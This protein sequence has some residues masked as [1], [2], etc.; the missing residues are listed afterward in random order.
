M[1]RS[2]GIPGVCVC[3]CGGGV[4]WG[5]GGAPTWVGTGVYM[6]AGV[7]VF[8][9]MLNYSSILLYDNFT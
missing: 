7:Q 6:R 9:L 1:V 4:C 8:V 5:W 3:V 2:S